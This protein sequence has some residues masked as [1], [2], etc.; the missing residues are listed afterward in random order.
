MSEITDTDSANG[1]MP[2]YGSASITSDTTAL[3]T[4]LAEIILKRQ[5]TEQRLAALE[6]GQ[7]KANEQLRNAH[8]QLDDAQSRLKVAQANQQSRLANAFLDGEDQT[9][10]PVISAKAALTASQDEINKYQTIEAALTNEAQK[11]SANLRAVR[12]IQHELIAEL[13]STSPEYQ[14]LIEAHKQ[15]WKQLRTIKTA[16]RTVTRGC[17]GYLPQNY[18]DEAS[19]V[20]PVEPRVGFDCFPLVSQWESVMQELGYSADV[21][22]PQS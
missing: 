9:D 8:W 14:A 17:A 2:D 15:A 16:L 1:A 6:A 11:V 5:E 12:S 10:D 21:L 20:E 7:L 22:F 13:V 3:R 19:K 18:I 4:R